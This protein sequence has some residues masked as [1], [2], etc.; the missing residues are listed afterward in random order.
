[1]L[2]VLSV[3]TPLAVG[4]KVNVTALVEPAGK[5]TTAGEKVPV[6][7]QRGVIAMACDEAAPE[8]GVM[9]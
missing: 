7:V 6:S 8:P 3:P 2:L 1:M 9:V 5:E 4:V